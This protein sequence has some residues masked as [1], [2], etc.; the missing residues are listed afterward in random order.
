MSHLV[1][2]RNQSGRKKDLHQTMQCQ[3]HRFFQTW[4]VHLSLNFFLKPNG[5]S[6][7]R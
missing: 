7:T 4:V 1:P 2:I 6:L 3:T 5:Q